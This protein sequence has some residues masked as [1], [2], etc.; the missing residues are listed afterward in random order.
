MD[1]CRGY[2]KT[3]RTVNLLD[4]LL[5][6]KATLAVAESL[7]GGHLQ[8]AITATPGISEVFEG[9]ITAYSLHQKTHLL[10]VTKT[11]AKRVGCVSV[12]VAI[13]MARGAAILF[14]TTYGIGTTGFADTAPHRK[15]P[16]AYWAIYNLPSEKIIIFNETLGEN[17]SRTQ[18]QEKTAGDALAA[19]IHHLS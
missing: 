10:G 6:N 18:M 19:L 12:Q 11:H 5:K 2:P 4:F 7:T 3:Y 14:G 13:E 9:G 8:A 1:S 16:Y 17:L 15:F